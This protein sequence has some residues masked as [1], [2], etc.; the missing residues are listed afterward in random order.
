MSFGGTK[1]STKQQQT[2]TQALDP[3]VKAAILGN[4]NN[5]SS[6]VSAY[7]PYAGSDV[8]DFT[9]LQNQSFGLV[10]D[11]ANN[12]TGASTLNA[13]IAATQRAASYIPSL[14]SAPA[15]APGLINRSDISNVTPSLVGNMDLSRYY[16]PYEGQV[17]DATT[18]A[19]R[20]N[21]NQTLTNNA[22]DAT[23]AGA[24]RGSALGVTNGVAEAQSNIGLAQTIGA[25]K[26]AGYSQ[27]LD[28]ATADANRGLTAAQSNQGVDLSTATTNAGNTQAANLQ[29]AINALQ[30]ST[31][32]QGAGLASAQLGLTA[33]ANLAQMGGQQLSDAVSRANVV[34]QAGNQQQQLNQAKL[35]FAYKNGYLNAQQ[36][37]VMLQNLKT[38]ALGLAG[39]PALTQSQGTSNQKSN[40]WS[41]DVSKALSLASTGGAGAAAGG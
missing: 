12:Q 5:V 21:L 20:N 16:N 2:S 41:V 29:N 6:N 8:A 32:N 14:V 26:Q 24:W 30:A 33:G 36:Y 3:D 4:Y 22:S 28:T 25:L 10:S 13:G 40:Q 11:I 1:S 15:A 39:D 35:D 17:V 18:A 37:A 27:A 34:N 19:A 31:S 23:R 9:P 38:Q 7:Q